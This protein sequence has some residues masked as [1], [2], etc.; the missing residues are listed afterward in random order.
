MKAYPTFFSNALRLVV[1]TLLL[2]SGV[3]FTHNAHAQAEV[4]PWGNMVGIRNKG[5]LYTFGSSLRVFGADGK[6]KA[7]TA[8]EKQSPKYSRLGD[9]QSVVTRIDSLFFKQTITEA[10][11]GKAKVKV[12]TIVKQDTTLQGLFFCITLPAAEYTGATVLLSGTKSDELNQGTSVLPNTFINTDAKAVEAVAATRKL[13]VD[14]E[15]LQRIVARVDA[16]GD[17]ELYIPLAM[18]MVHRGDT[19]RKEFTIKAQGDVDEQPVNIA[20]NTTQRGRAFAGLGGNFRLQ[21]P[22]T[23]PQVI[24]YSLQNLRVAWGRVELPWRFWQ[25]NKDVNPAGGELTPFVLKSMQM[26]KRLDSAGMPIILS[27]WAPPAWAVVGEPRFQPTPE[28]VWGNPL[29][30]DNDEAI[31]KSITD[32]ILYMKSHFGFEVKMFSFNES[33]LGINIRQTAEEHRN[34]IKGLGAYMASKGLRTKVMLGDNSDATTY[35]FIYPAMADPEARKYI[36][37]IS[38]H[39][40]RGWE[41]ETL[42]KWADAATQLNLPLIVGEGSIDAAAWN[43]PGIFQETTYALEEIN[44]YARMLAICQPETIL[45]WQLTADYSPLIGG[46]IFGNNEPLHPGQRFWNLKQLATTPKGLFAMPVS[47]DRPGISA[48]AMGDNG[49]TTYAL[50]LVNNGSTRDVVLSGLPASITHLRYYITNTKMN[51][52]EE[53]VEV[54]DGVAKFKLPAVSFVSLMTK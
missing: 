18:G 53:D 7:F 31:Y 8:K 11:P 49:T 6:H 48:A 21:N 34:F 9:A 24:D 25:P 41:T 51:M 47:A 20:I 43:Y 13:N 16:S 35:N 4:Q 17:I 33:D 3:L 14:F 30:H 1:C 23:D 19:L 27:A 46:G 32:Y 42:Q 36:G 10:G 2:I 29:N 26:A 37:A 45:Q 15:S 44:L 50:H 28:G 5:Q 52:K 12:E 38:F 22:K 40:W 39:S 54:K